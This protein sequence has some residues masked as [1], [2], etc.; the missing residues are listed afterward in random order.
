MPCA[1]PR[2]FLPLFAAALA[3][4]AGAEELP[5]AA[6]ENEG[7]NKRVRAIDQRALGRLPSARRLRVPTP[8]E[9]GRFV[10]T[11]SRIGPGERQAV[12]IRRAED[13]SWELRLMWRRTD[14]FWLDTGWQKR[15]E[16]AYKGHDGFIEIEVDQERSNEHEIVARFR[17]EQNGERK[18][19]AAESGELVIHR[20]DTTG[21]TLSWHIDPMTTVVTVGEALYPDEEEKKIVD[22]RLWIMSKVAE[23]MIEWDEILW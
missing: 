10:G 14:D 5:L 20:S 11:W 6:Q 1:A 9:R 16:Y 21:R 2:R 15:K 18:S 13:G 12:Q 3:L 4:L 7:Q 8:T 22:R 23:R 19:V 17:R